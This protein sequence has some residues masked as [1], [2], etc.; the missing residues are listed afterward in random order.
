MIPH[1]CYHFSSIGFQLLVRTI[2][3]RVNSG[4]FLSYNC[5]DKSMYFYQ[6]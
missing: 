2:H 5:I 4:T 6:Y 1:Y 3:V